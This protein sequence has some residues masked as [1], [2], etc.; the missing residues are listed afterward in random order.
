M[1]VFMSFRINRTEMDYFYATQEL[2]KFQHDF[3]WIFPA[4]KHFFK[5]VTD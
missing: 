4:A 1:Q 3:N 5:K 2:T